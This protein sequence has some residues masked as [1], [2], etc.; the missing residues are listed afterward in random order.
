MTCIWMKSNR[1]GMDFQRENG[2]MKNFPLENA[3]T[4]WLRIKVAPDHGFPTS[5]PIHAGLPIFR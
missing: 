5:Q 2:P 4:I 3:Q 1:F